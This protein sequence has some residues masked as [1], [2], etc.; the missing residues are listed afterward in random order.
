MGDQSALLFLVAGMAL[1]VLRS[2]YLVWKSGKIV[3]EKRGHRLEKDHEPAR[4]K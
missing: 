3:A 2:L 4:R 1:L